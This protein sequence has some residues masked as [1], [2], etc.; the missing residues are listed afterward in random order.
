[1]WKSY[2][3]IQC[4]SKLNKHFHML[5]IRYS[6]RSDATHVYRHKPNLSSFFLMPPGIVILF[7]FARCS[8]VAKIMSTQE[9]ALLFSMSRWFL[10]QVSNGSFVNVTEYTHSNERR[11]TRGISSMK[12]KCASAGREIRLSS[13]HWWNRAAR[14]KGL[15]AQPAEVHFQ[16]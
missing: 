3:H 5:T 12:P 6:F 7:L 4:H 2:M 16:T 1:M 11:F 8:S 9:K 10:L 14:Q 15:S 13:H